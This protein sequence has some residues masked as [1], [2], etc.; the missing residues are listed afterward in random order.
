MRLR[1]HTPITILLFL[2]GWAAGANPAVFNVRDHGAVGDGKSDDTAALNQAV[3][4]CAAAGGG[5]V[6]VPAGRYLSGTVHLKSNVTLLLDA[7]AEI[8]G[9]ADL[10]RYDNFTP[11]GDT[12]LARRLRWHRA[13]V[14]GVGVENVTITGRGT[15]N[16]NQ[17]FDPQGEERMRG[18]HAIL[19]GKNAR[20]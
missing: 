11:P 3:E 7:G 12:P 9:T 1:F 10:A 17:V 15:I 4:A 19:F 6:L 16:G 5:Q 13:L 2:G 14:L 8:V 18:P 20:L